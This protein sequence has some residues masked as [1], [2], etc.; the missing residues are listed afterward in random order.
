MPR[1]YR[2]PSKELIGEVTTEQLEQLIDLLEEEDEEDRDYYIDK[3]T[4]ELLRDN[5]CDAALV[6][7]LETALGDATDLDI[8]WEADS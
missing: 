2:L 3:D 7:L 4:L 8:L 6:T 1:I 5:H